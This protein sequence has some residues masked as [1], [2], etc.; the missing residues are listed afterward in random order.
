MT[1][2]GIL[3]IDPLE[4]C[5]NDF[6]ST[7]SHRL[8]VCTSTDSYYY[9]SAYTWWQ[10]RNTFPQGS[11]GPIFKIPKYVIS[12][13]PTEPTFEWTKFFCDISLT[14]LDINISCVGNPILLNFLQVYSCCNLFWSCFI[15]NFTMVGIFMLLHIEYI[16]WE[17]KHVLYVTD[18]LIHKTESRD[19]IASKKSIK[20]WMMSTF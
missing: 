5:G 15:D 8:T 4:L 13:E 3:K 12:N 11:N 18:L 1:F 17:Y 20:Y 2:F 7:G 14:L 9:F 19:A 6:Q 16:D 10:K